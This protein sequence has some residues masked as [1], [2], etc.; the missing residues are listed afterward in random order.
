MVNF[1]HIYMQMF[2]LS[3]SV[4]VVSFCLITASLRN[5]CGP[6][7]HHLQDDGRHR[8][9]HRFVEDRVRVVPFGGRFL[10]ADLPAILQ[11]INFD[12]RI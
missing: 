5:S 3:V 8:E 12:K 10:F 9:Y 11:K 2:V 1:S 6:N 4:A 7:W